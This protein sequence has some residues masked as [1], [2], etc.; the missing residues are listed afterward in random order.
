[1]ELEEK[2]KASDSPV[3]ESFVF[4]E[5]LVGEYSSSIPV[6]GSQAATQPAS[7]PPNSPTS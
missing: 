3:L 4:K 6:V 5:E 1:M 2:G 7:K